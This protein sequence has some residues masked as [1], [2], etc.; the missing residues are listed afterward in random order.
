MRN[1]RTVNATLPGPLYGIVATLVL[2]VYFTV[3]F[4]L[5]FLVPYLAAWLFARDRESAF[6]Q[7]NC[8][9]Y[10]GLFLLI[11]WLMPSHKWQIDNSLRKIRGAVIVCNHLSYLD[12]LIMI[13]LFERH[14]T[15]VKARFFAVP[16]FAWFVKTAG[17]LPSTA[18][19]GYGAIMIDQMENMEQF[20]VAGGNLFIFPEGT[21]SRNGRLNTFNKGAF[22]IARLCQAPLKVLR[23][24]NSDKLYTPGKFVFNTGLDN[25]ISVTIAGEINPDYQEKSPSVKEL[26][27]Q[28]WAILNRD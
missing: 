11:R 19:G 25:T 6:Q 28:V 26:E 20:L 15:V 9:F 12:P 8:R 1:K 18:E 16:I 14:K 21:R 17:Y 3:G 5:I 13:S 27:Q 24:R 4:V 10:R 2:W 22:K 7:L 23:I